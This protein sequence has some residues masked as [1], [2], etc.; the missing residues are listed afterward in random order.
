MGKLRTILAE[1]LIADDQAGDW[2]A[3]A[4]NQAA[5]AVIVGVGLSL[6]L[7]LAGI[8]PYIAAPCV[9]VAYLV[10][11]EFVIQRGHDWRDSV[12]DAA[13]VGFGAAIVPLALIDDLTGLTV[14]FVAWLALLAFGVWRRA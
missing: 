12:M 2:Y 3:W 5:H 8:G 1:L 9:A 7:I 6:A 14:A 13:H 10:L 11:W 4:V